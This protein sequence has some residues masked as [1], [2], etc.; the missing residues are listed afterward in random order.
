MDFNELFSEE[1]EAD[2]SKILHD[3]PSEESA[4]RFLD[5]LKAIVELTKT[6]PKAFQIQY[7]DVRVVVF[8]KLPF[9]L[10]YKIIEPDIVYIIAIVYQKEDA[11][12]WQNRV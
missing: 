2:V 1:A 6:Y 7:K 9:K 8:Q 10:V 3:A 12:S 4:I 5:S 11:G